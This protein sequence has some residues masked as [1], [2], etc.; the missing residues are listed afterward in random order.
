MAMYLVNAFSLNMLSGDNVTIT[1]R[2]LTVDEAKELLAP[3]GRLASNVVIAIGHADTAAIVGNLL[4]L[5]E[6][7]IARMV[8]AAKTRPTVK[9]TSSD[10]AVVAQYIGPR[11][12]EGATKLPEGAR[13]EFFL[14]TLE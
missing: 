11:L 6:E 4:G 2:K 9:M 7:D 3:D 8:E 5:P 10:K 12:P 14:V 1:I 13:V